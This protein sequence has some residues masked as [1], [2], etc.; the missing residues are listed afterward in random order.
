MRR[1][2]ASNF[3][4]TIWAV[5]GGFILHFLLSNY[6]TVLLRPI[7]EEPVETAA[8][9]IKRDIIPYYYPGAEFFRQFLAASPDP[10]YQALS[11]KLLI[12]KDWD[13]YEAIAKMFSTGSYAQI[14][15]FAKATMYKSSEI[16]GGFNPYSLH[17]TNKKWPL[18]KVFLMILY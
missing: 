8:D 5:C 13:E 12:P 16:I 18:K 11:E 14:A 15:G 3:V 7:Y 2:L 17:L 4:Y 10:N 9:L 6:L 1:S